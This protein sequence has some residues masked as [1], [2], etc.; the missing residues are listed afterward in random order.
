MYQLVIFDLDGTL[1]NTVA[2][3]AASTNFVLKKNG[4]PQHEISEFYF[5]IGNGINKLFER[6]LPEGEKNDENI[7][8][9]RKDFLHHYDNHNTDLTIPYDGIDKLLKNLQKKGINMAVASNKY[10]SGTVKL[11]NHYF[12]DISFS[13]ILGQ[14]EGVPVKPDPAIVN[15]ILSLTGIKSE[16]TL[17]V[18]DSGVD[19]ETANNSGVTA[20]GVTWGFRPKSELE[21]FSPAYI[22]NHPDEILKK[23]RARKE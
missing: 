1:L 20:I 9:L 2:D 8:K 13:A 10:H 16:N 19:M 18:G 6:A 15:E 23:L 4:F 17:Y 3:L 21:M 11:I 7:L 14:R 12:P 5:Y 22:V